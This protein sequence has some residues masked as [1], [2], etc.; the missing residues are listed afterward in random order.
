MAYKRIGTKLN[1]KNSEFV[2]EIVKSKADNALTD[3]AIDFFI[4]LAN[5]AVKRLQ[6]SDPRDREDCIQS[7]LLDLT[8]YWRNFDP[9]KSNNAFAY[10]TQMAKNGY[11][12]QFK[13]IHKH[14]FNKRSRVL[15]PGETDGTAKGL[16][17]AME[18]SVM[19]FTQEPAFSFARVKRVR[20]AVP[21]EGKWCKWTQ[22]DPEDER[23]LEL[24]VLCLGCRIFV[25]FK[26]EFDD[27]YETISLDYGG[28]SSIYTI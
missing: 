22:F 15:K 11:A 24:E 12:K 8:K 5:H 4:K 13:Q 1:I 17:A 20:P 16:V 6:Y 18:R 10:F 9:E 3:R 14:R 23:T 21:E 28:P 2:E 25:E 19:E 27:G 26:F 7:A